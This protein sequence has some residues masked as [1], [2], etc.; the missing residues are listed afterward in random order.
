MELLDS[1]SGTVRSTAGRCARGAALAAS[2]THVVTLMHTTD[3]PATHPDLNSCALPLTCA[4]TSRTAEGSTS[5]AQAPAARR[6]SSSRQTRCGHNQTVTSRPIHSPTSRPHP[7]DDGHSWCIARPDT[8]IA[9]AARRSHSGLHPSTTRQAGIVRLHC[10][11][12]PA[13]PW[14]QAGSLQTPLQA[15]AT[16][17][18]LGV[19]HTARCPSTH[20]DQRSA[21][22]RLPSILRTHLQKRRLSLKCPAG[23]RHPSRLCPPTGHARRRGRGER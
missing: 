16:I 19:H 5:S 1:T 20:R 14:E 8:Q 13:S 4:E 11:E 7:C 22:T 12:G 21:Q 6:K 18:V 15:K 10:Q 23:P 17:E 2:S 9:V 3:P